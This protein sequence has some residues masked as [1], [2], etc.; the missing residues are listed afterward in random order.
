MQYMRA[1]TS[2]FNHPKW[3]MNLLCGGVCM[4]IPIIGPIVFLGY[5]AELVA[6]QRTAMDP[7]ALA[8]DFNRFTDY[9]SKGWQAFVV[10][11]IVSLVM[12]PVTL[13]CLLFFIAAAMVGEDAPAMAA[14]LFIIGFVIFIV[15]QMGVMV[16]M[17]PCVLRAGLTQDFKEGL[18]L[19]PMREFMERVGW[20]VF[21]VTMFSMILG[22]VLTF[23]GYLMCIIGLYPAMALMFLTQWHL[24]GQLHLLYL[25]RGGTP[26]PISP[27]LLGEATDASQESSPQA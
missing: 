27:V 25:K 16:V 17:V 24:F 13:V 6:R 12:V 18:R 1:L 7:P 21:A 26:I 14:L 3:A 23:V 4:L 22:I 9:L 2:T 19:G 20:Q 15:L 10:A 11:L 8:F 5:L